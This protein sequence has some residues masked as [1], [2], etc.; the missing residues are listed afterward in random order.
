MKEKVLKQCGFCRRENIPRISTTVVSPSNNLLFSHPHQRVRVNNDH[1]LYSAWN[2]LA[3]SVYNIPSPTHPNDFPTCQKSHHQRKKPSKQPYPPYAV[4]RR[5]QSSIK[6]TWEKRQAYTHFIPAVFAL[7][8]Y[9]QI[10]CKFK[11]N[12]QS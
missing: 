6:G 4:F 5:A 10:R 1:P 2:L 12:L 3:V 11:A 7:T 8:K 9:G